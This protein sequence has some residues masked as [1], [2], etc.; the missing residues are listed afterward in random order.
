MPA[1][2]GCRSGQALSKAEGSVEDPRRRHG[3]RGDGTSLAE[4]KKD[5]SRRDAG[6]PRR[7]GKMR[8]TDLPTFIPSCS[9]PLRPRS[10]ALRAGSAG[11]DLVAAS[12]RTRLCRAKRSQ[13]SADGIGG[14]RLPD[15]GVYKRWE[16]WPSEQTKRAPSKAGAIQQV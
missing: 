12:L 16:V 15:R 11:V 14:G 6:T 13:F 4:A 2:F 5:V 7:E 9:A 8:E 1:P 3:D 10:A